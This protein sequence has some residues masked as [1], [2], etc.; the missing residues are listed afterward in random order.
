MNPTPREIDDEAQ[1][2]IDEFLAKGG[3][4]EQCKPFA[5]TENLETKGGFYGRKPK[6]KK[7][8]E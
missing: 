2:A 5:R 1:K 7:E 4:I 8:E 6:K 3:V